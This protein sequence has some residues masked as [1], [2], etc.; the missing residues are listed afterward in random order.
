[1]SKI[2]SIVALSGGKDSVATLLKVLEEGW[3]PEVVFCDTG[4]ES[5]IL[6]EYLKYLEDQL[7]IKIKFLKSNKYASF[8]DMVIRK[9][10][11]PSTMARFCTEELKVKPMINYILDEVKGNFV[12]FQGIRAEESLKRRQ[13]QP[14]CTYFKYYLEPYG[15]DKNGNPK[16]HTYRRKEVLEFVEKYIHDVQRPVF[17]LTANEV[18]DI[19]DVFGVKPNPLYKEAFGRV[20][21][22]PCI[23]ANLSEIWNIYLRYPARI[24][25][26]IDWEETVGTTFFPPQFVPFRYASKEVTF[27][28]DKSKL[29]TEEIEYLTDQLE[30]VWDEKGKAQGIM[31][32]NTMK[33]VIRYLKDKHAQGSLFEQYDSKTITSCDS[34]YNIC[35]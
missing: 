15:H 7:G 1:M 18:F 17:H 21:C 24:E 8:I 13:M 11:F 32:V 35:E 19:H 29:S 33:D 12:V 27:K 34:I 14:S 6:Y 4:W 20:G 16:Y 3:K 22:F 25:E 26:I 23:Q 5:P 10:R 28:Y 30:I 9:K 31:K 2:K